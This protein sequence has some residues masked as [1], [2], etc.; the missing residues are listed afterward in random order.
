[1]SDRE[2]IRFRLIILLICLNVLAVLYIYYLLNGSILYSRSENN[3]FLVRKDCALSNTNI[4]K[5]DYMVISDV[6]LSLAQAYPTYKRGVWDC[7]QYSQL[8]VNELKKIGYNATCVFGV[9]NELKL[10]KN[11]STVRYN[12]PHTWVVVNSDGKDLFVEATNGDI[13]SDYYYDENYLE[14]VR[15]KCL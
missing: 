10:G 3:F 12:Y 6:A 7:T 9:Y 5:E 14:R 13:I 8:L 15:G 4:S 2:T 11:N 1:M